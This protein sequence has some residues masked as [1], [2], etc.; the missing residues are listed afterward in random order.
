MQPCSSKKA[1]KYYVKM[2]ILPVLC[3]PVSKPRKKYIKHQCYNQGNGS[4]HSYWYTALKCNP[5]DLRDERKQFPELAK[6]ARLVLAVPASSALTERVFSKLGRVCAKD[7]AHMKPQM[8]DAL[9]FLASN[10]HWK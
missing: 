2:K 9:T 5:L 7:R 6:V 1:K 10:Q 3:L 4:I 8:A